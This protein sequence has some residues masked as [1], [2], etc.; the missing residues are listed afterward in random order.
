MQIL[1]NNPY[2]FHFRNCLLKKKK[3]FLKRL[4]HYIMPLAKGGERTVLHGFL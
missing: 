1:Q 3:V 2:L 4:S